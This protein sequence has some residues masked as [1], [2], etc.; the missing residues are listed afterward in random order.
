[1]HN[2]EA[3][4]FAMTIIAT[5]KTNLLRQISEYHMM[6]KYAEKGILLNRRGEWG[7]NLPPKLTVDDGSIGG[8]KR[9][10]ET[11]RGSGACMNDPKGG[12]NGA[13]TTPAPPAKKSRRKGPSGQNSLESRVT[14]A[15]KI[16]TVKG[17]LSKL[18]RIGSPKQAD[19]HMP[20]ASFNSLRLKS[21]S[22]GVSTGVITKEVQSSTNLIN[23]RVK[24]SNNEHPIMTQ[25]LYMGADKELEHQVVLN[26]HSITRKQKTT[27]EGNCSG[28]PSETQ[29][30]SESFGDLL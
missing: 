26:N 28:P 25:N 17:M 24:V 23:L 15:P 13:V 2:G 10:L 14:L 16:L 7:Q 1:M 19:S 11:Q 6:L 4:E 22:F 8:P 20:R 30:N 5:P 18:G 9:S 21:R 3:A 27:E 29:N 12:P